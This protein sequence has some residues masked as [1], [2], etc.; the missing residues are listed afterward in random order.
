M[1][2]KQDLKKTLEDILVD[3]REYD[4]LVAELATQNGVT[5]AEAV[6]AIRLKH[7]TNDPFDPRDDLSFDVVVVFGSVT[8]TTNPSNTATSRTWRMQVDVGGKLSWREEKD[9]ESG[10]FAVLELAGVMSCVDDRLNMAS[11]IS[12]MNPEGS[13]GS[14]IPL[15]DEENGTLQLTEQWLMNKTQLAAHR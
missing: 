13:E 11:G 2:D 8:E 12:S 1:S 10:T 4:P 6:N 5:E 7:E 3:L 14:A 15:E 9:N